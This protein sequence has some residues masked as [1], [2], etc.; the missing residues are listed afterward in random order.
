MKHPPT[1]C[2]ECERACKPGTEPIYTDRKG[3]PR[4]L[5]SK[6]C[7]KKYNGEDQDYTPEPED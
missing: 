4:G 7:Q 1:L 3:I 2:A 5:C 6:R